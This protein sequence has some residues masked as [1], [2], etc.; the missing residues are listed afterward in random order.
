MKEEKY[1]RRIRILQTIEENRKQKI[2]K[3]KT[4]KNI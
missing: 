4:I 1:L 2:K 3:K